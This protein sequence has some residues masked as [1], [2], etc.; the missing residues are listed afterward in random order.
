HAVANHLETLRPLGI[1]PTGEEPRLDFYPAAA[2]LRFAADYFSRHGLDGAT[3]VAFNPGTSHLCKCWPV[4]RFALLG[5]RLADELGA[6]IVIPGSRD[7]KE[8]ADGI[9][10]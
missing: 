7:E 4:D 2:D 5:D 10:A 6:R 9:A 3:V 8:L 1:E